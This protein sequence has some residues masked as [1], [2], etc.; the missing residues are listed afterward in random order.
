MLTL[1]VPLSVQVLIGTVANTAML[2][3]VV[4]LGCVL[5]GLLALY[6]LLIGIQAH[7][8]DVFERRLFARITKDILNQPITDT[9]DVIIEPS[10]SGWAASS[11][12]AIA[13]NARAQ[14]QGPRVAIAVDDRTIRVSIPESD[15]Q[16]RAGFLADVMSAD[17]NTTLLDLP[18]QVICN[19]KTGSII[20]TGDVQI[21]PVAITHKDLNVTTTIPPPVPSPQ[22]PLVERDQWMALKTEGKPSEVAKLSDL[23]KAFKQ[24]DIPVEEQIGILQMLHKTGKLQAKLIVD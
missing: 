6:G 15:R 16:D 22:N 5:F 3:P 9:F 1:A 18:A 13:I 10:F 11:Q 4:V 21:S 19:Q 17:V 7:L 8:M 20:V 2:R 23:I 14:P 24:L 12:I